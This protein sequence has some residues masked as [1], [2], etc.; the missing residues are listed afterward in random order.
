MLLEGIMILDI[1]QIKQKLRQIHTKHTRNTQET[2]KNNKKVLEN[3]QIFM[4]TYIKFMD[5]K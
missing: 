4:Y 2:S 1:L 5:G 3:T